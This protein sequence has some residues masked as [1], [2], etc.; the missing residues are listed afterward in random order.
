M[1][2]ISDIQPIKAG[3][4]APHGDSG[5]YGSVE[6]VRNKLQNTDPDGVAT[7]GAAYIRAAEVLHD[8][9]SLLESVA[10]TM[11]GDWKD[12]SSAQAQQ[13]LRM[14]HASARELS[15]RARQV[16]AAHN[17]YADELRKARANLPESGWFTWDD[18]IGANWKTISP[19][20]IVSD[21]IAGDTDSDNDKARKH[22]EELNKQITAVYNKLP[23]DVTTVLP[24]PGPPITVP[25]TP[26]VDPYTGSPYT[27]SPYTG[28]AGMPK[29][30]GTGLD[31]AL[32]N[33][34][35]STGGPKVP[36]PDVTGPGTGGP[37]GPGTGAPPSTGGPGD[38]GT[39]LP[40]GTPPGSVPN[41]GQPPVLDPNDPRSTNLAGTNPTTMP[42]GTTQLNT[43]PG[44]N[45]N[46]VPTLTNPTGTIPPGGYTGP[47][48]TVPYGGGPLGAGGGTSYGAPGGGG[49][50]AAGV[51]GRAAAANGAM[52]GMPFMPMG[53][54]GGEA[55][56]ER[57][58]ST[59]LTEDES[60]WGGD[61]PVAPTVIS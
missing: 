10:G 24:A 2:R 3:T 35:G 47:L 37:G 42:P 40:G 4:A 28:G 43:P 46:A 54:A 8:T 29:F 14:L 59:W 52:G 30:S 22:L 6:S 21:A 33:P 11:A 12:K 1:N 19:I 18:D 61:G 39:G 16:G 49:A 50:G 25:V 5:S 44:L 58:R 41:G 38:P 23:P 32:L 48:G 45:P 7:A 31:G 36:G 9:M 34:D 15:E 27:G 13:A 20:T 17:L 26:V 53:G 51:N 57:E 60:V 56:Q 55:N